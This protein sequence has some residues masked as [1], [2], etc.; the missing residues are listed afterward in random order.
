MIAQRL[1]PVRARPTFLTVMVAVM[2]AITVSACGGDGKA[3]RTTAKNG[4]T[5]TLPGGA[6]GG[7]SGG[8]AS[9]SGG[10]SSSGG[11]VGVAPIVNLPVA[12]PI[13]TSD[14]AIA[15]YTNTLHPVL[16][17]NC[18]RCHGDGGVANPLFVF[19]DV[20]QA[21]HALEQRAWVE[22]DVPEKSRLVTRVSVDQHACWTTC[23]AD[24]QTLIDAITNWSLML[25]KT[26][27]TPPPVVAQPTDIVS[28]AVTSASV[29][30]TPAGA[31]RISNGII[32]LYEFKDGTGTV[33]RDTSGV[34]PA[35]DLAFTGTVNWLP[36][37]GIEFTSGSK[38]TATAANSR[39]L[40]DRLN[41][42]GAYTVEAWIAPGNGAATGAIVAYGQ[43]N[44]NR[45]FA[46]T[47][48]QS[49][50]EFS[51]RPSTANANTRAGGIPPFS[52]DSSPAQPS[53][54]HLVVT[55]TR[56]S[57]QSI[58]V[59]GAKIAT[60]ST[61]VA[62]AGWN[63]AYTLSLGNEG[64]NQASWQGQMKLVTVYERA[65]SDSEVLQN[66]D[67]GIGMTNVLSF[68]VSPVTGVAG[69]AITME[70]ADFDKSAYYFGRPT[71]IAPT[72]LAA[73]IPV[74][75]LR[76]A[77]N[78][79][80]PVASQAFYSLKTVVDTVPFRLSRQGTV[81]AKDQGAGDTFSLTFEVLGVKQNI[82]AQPSPTS[83][84]VD[85]SVVLNVP[86][87]GIRTFEQINNTMAALTGVDPT[88][89]AVLTTFNNIRQQL[90]SEPDIKG[91]LS[92]QQTALSRLALD[93][94]DAMVESQP[95][96][97]AFF[98]T[99]PAFEFAAAPATA[100]ST[101][102][103]KDLVMTKLVSNMV[104]VNIATQPVA[105]ELTPALQTVIDGMLASC[106][107]TTTI[108]CT[109]ATR[110]RAIVKAACASVLS[111]AAILIQ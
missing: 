88:T 73:P 2:L 17:T 7:S 23:S 67:A 8:G 15:A 40:T 51:H 41:T 86:D 33:A 93:Y 60:S 98:G 34:A 20:I 32:A 56:T 79:K 43:D 95:L 45:N 81:I 10:G 44:A 30:S 59:N 24:A 27:G 87:A 1:S 94:C 16:V 76:I 37:Q 52:T 14:P 109:N 49:N 9:T 4:T 36:T 80:P 75:G 77:I 96:R 11:T 84:P 28:A 54:Q 82:V 64:N 42:S 92:S 66:F 48:N 97:D 63:A 71:F 58:Y 5:P 102:A 50:Y 105:T 111:S 19:N 62:L 57:G 25:G 65:L 31:G 12:G 13:D 47:Q 53:L 6:I 55:Y 35:A 21:H 101:Q 3:K 72:T 39:K 68:D 103:K 100:F 107:T 29:V 104:G 110:T 70:F 26:P 78:G 83:P 90:P 46:V 89:T 38:A 108:N 22:L 106:R 69:S 74:Q 99:T 61:A 85:N 18:A 91:F